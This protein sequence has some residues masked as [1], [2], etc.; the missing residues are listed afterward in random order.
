MVKLKKVND[1]LYQYHDEQ[2]N[3]LF[4]MKFGDR[5]GFEQRFRMVS[6]TRL[7]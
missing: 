4:T 5:G 1:K 2:N 7:P 6:K 3:M